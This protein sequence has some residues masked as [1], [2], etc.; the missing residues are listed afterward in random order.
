MIAEAKSDWYLILDADEIYRKSA[1]DKL[2]EHMP[3]MQHE[4]DENGKVYGVVK[5]FEVAHDLNSIHGLN[6]FVRHHRV[7]H[8]TAIWTG[9]HPGEVAVT[10]QKPHT[11]HL[12][13]KEVGCYHFHQPDR[14][15]LDETVPRR[16][17]RRY[18]KT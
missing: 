11:E 8:R 16:L 6:E 13:P 7:Y 10:P 4:Y 17:S 9:T 15:P 18:Q 12:F 2:I 14:S 3:T 5:R 1:L